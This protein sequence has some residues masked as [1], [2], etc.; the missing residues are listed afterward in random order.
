[1]T[2]QLSGPEKHQLKIARSTLSMSLSGAMIMGGPNHAEAREI[3]ERLTGKR[4]PVLPS[5]GDRE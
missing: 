5:H 4:A 3:I 1:M 2:R